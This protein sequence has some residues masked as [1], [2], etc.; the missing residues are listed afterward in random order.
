MGKKDRKKS[1][2]ETSVTAVGWTV[3]SKRGWKL[4]GTGVGVL[5]L[6]Y[7]V[8]SLTDPSGQNWASHLS[9]FLLIAGYTLIGVGIVIRNPA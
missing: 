5:V 7:I 8:L 3:I 9:P 1:V 4:V 6:G 2:E